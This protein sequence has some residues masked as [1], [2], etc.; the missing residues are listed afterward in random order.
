MWAWL[1]QRV[2]AVALLLDLGV[3]LGWHRA[4]FWLALGLSAALFVV[5]WTGRWY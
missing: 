4:L 5:V 1:V 3:P 2:A